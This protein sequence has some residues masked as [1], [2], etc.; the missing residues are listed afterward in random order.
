LTLTTGNK[1]GE[2]KKWKEQQPLTNIS[3]INM[4]ILYQITNRQLLYFSFDNK[5]FVKLYK[6]VVVLAAIFLSN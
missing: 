4:A 1:Y 2:F 5:L 6:T 3:K